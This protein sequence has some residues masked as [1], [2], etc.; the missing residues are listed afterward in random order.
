MAIG[1]NCGALGGL[2][3]MIMLSP[4]WISN[5][6]TLP[7][8]SWSTLSVSFSRG[9]LCGGAGSGLCKSDGVDGFFLDGDVRGIVAA[10]RVGLDNGG[11]TP[12]VGGL[13]SFP[14]RELGGGGFFLVI[15]GAGCRPV[16]GLLI[17]PWCSSSASEDFPVVWGVSRT[18]GDVSVMGCC[19]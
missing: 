8:A 3:G 13:M 19:T 17:I 16:W 12:S 6:G 11:S 9:D 5:S 7:A 18:A 2:V 14:C 15:V 4:G 1:L 10:L